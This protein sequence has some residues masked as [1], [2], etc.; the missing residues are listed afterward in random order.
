MLAAYFAVRI[1]SIGSQN[2]Q[3]LTNNKPN[4]DVM[5]QVKLK[6][7]LRPNMSEIMPNAKAPI[8][9]GKDEQRTR[10]NESMVYLRKSG[11]CTSV[12]STLATGWDIELLAKECESG[13][14]I[15]Q[16]VTY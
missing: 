12:N 7:H 4:T 9:F 13:H 1:L 10:L 5:R 16:L 3:K 11:I 6:A 2:G 8:L 15:M 14:E